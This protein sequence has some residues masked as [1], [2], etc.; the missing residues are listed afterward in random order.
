MEG[1]GTIPERLPGR[2]ELLK[3]MMCIVGERADIEGKKKGAKEKV[4]AESKGQESTPHGWNFQDEEADSKKGS[5]SEMAPD[6]GKGG[7]GRGCPI[8]ADNRHPA[9]VRNPGQSS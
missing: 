6:G 8:P 1:K 4:G 2:G 5:L 9:L 3:D 7:E